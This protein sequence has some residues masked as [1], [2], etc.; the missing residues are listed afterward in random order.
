M[1]TGNYDYITPISNVKMQS[2][3]ERAFMYI[4]R[5]LKLTDPQIVGLCL[6]KT[7]LKE[8]IANGD[9]GKP[10]IVLSDGGT[11]AYLYYHGEGGFCS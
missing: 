4:T 8:I 3:G 10:E 1:Y 5:E 6:A 11:M 2:D 9:V 7:K